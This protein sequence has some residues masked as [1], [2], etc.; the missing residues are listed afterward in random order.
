[1]GGADAD[2]DG[3]DEKE[4]EVESWASAMGTSGDICN[5]A[6]TAGS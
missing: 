2:D 6:T 5:S 3:E 4:E 1:M